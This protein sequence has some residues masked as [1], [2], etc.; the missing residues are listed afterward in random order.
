MWMEP[1]SHLPRRLV[2]S[3]DWHQL[4]VDE[5][6]R[7]RV[8]RHRRHGRHPLRVHLRHHHIR[9]GARQG[10]R[11][12]GGSHPG[13]HC[14]GG[15]VRADQGGCV[16]AAAD[17]WLGAVP[18]LQAGRCGIGEAPAATAADCRCVKHD[19]DTVHS[20]WDERKGAMSELISSRMSGGGGGG[21]VSVGPV[22]VFGLVARMLLRHVSAHLSESRSREGFDN[23]WEHRT[24]HTQKC[25]FRSAVSFLP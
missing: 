21:G 10:S 16:A 22:C 24:P 23:R 11:P 13:H 19:L 15:V 20:R 12:Q 6:A 25:A 14:D 9:R 4:S 3:T 17:Q 5:A 1:T 8:E 2:C 18:G 7:L